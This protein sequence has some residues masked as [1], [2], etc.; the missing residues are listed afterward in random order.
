M[1]SWFAPALVAFQDLPAMQALIQSFLGCLRNVT[2][3]AI[4]GT[5]LFVLFFV[6]T[7][8]LGLGLLILFPM[9]VASVYIGYRD[10]FAGSVNPR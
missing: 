9:I 8:P 3:F 10:I 1:A 7:I 5:V 2:A 6:A 4:Y